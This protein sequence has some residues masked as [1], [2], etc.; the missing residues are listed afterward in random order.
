MFL[1][2]SWFVCLLFL[3]VLVWVFFEFVR[4]EVLYY[5]GD[6][7]FYVIMIIGLMMSNLLLL[8]DGFL[9]EILMF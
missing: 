8:F 3:V 9:M 2:F 1:G 5:C 6:I 7:L 4:S